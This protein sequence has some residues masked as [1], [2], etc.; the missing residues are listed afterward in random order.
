MNA[1][2][3]KW[4]DYIFYISM[5]EKKNIAFSIHLNLIKFMKIITH[6]H[7]YAFLTFNTGVAVYS[8]SASAGL[9]K[10]SLR[11]CYSQITRPLWLA[12]A[13]RS[14]LAKFKGEIEN[15]DNNVANFSKHFTPPAPQL[16]PFW[17]NKNLLWLNF[18]TETSEGAIAN[19]KTINTEDV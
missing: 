13:K 5:G 19:I 3:Y 17:G 4:F 15:L 18:D 12:T 16:F 6:I 8:R 7:F 14:S 2:V 10:Y 11:R 1:W 9:C